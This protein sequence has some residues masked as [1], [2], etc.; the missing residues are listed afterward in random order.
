MVKLKCHFCWHVQNMVKP[1]LAEIGNIAAAL[2]VTLSMEGVVFCSSLYHSST[3]IA[4]EMYFVAHSKLSPKV[5]QNW[6]VV[7]EAPTRSV[8]H[9]CGAI[10]RWAFLRG[11]SVNILCSSSSSC[12][13]VQRIAFAFASFTST[14]PYSLTSLFF[15]A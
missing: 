2:N 7:S 6:I 10:R 3:G 1:V 14:L 9:R 11:V 5:G 8:H 4:L 15:T 13:M 12:K